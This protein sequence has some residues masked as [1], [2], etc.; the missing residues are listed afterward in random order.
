MAR[1]LHE[2]LKKEMNKVHLERSV[3]EGWHRRQ[4]EF[5]GFK[6]AFEAAT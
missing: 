4:R 6:S 2:L 1:R 5:G 3:A